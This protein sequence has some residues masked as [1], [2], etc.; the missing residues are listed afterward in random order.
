KRLN[1]PK[2]RRPKPRSRQRPNSSAD[3]AVA[4]VFF[5][6]MSPKT[7]TRPRSMTSATESPAQTVRTTVAGLRA[8]VLALSLLLPACGERNTAGLVERPLSASEQS[9]RLVDSSTERFRYQTRPAAA[10]ESPAP[11]GLIYD[12]PEG[13]TEKP[14]SP[15][16]DV[17]F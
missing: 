4:V 7:P 3:R 12:T 11:R 9:F 2:R 16:R 15:M 14:G 13:W 10:S 17:N 6:R 8:A 5:Q 1:P